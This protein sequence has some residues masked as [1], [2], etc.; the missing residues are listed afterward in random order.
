M[1]IQRIVNGRP[2]TFILTWE[3]VTKTHEEFVLNFMKNTLINDFGLDEEAAEIHSCIAY[4]IYSLGNGLTEYESIQ[5]AYDEY[6]DNL[7]KFTEKD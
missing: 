5:K 4:D 2:R 6:Q 7:E 1:K 3:E